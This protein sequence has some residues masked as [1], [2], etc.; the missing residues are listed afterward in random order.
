[1]IYVNG[2][3]DIKNPMNEK[4]EI[5]L[6]LNYKLNLKKNSFEYLTDKKPK[7]FEFKKKVT[8]SDNNFQ[9]VESYKYSSKTKMK[10]ENVVKI[11]RFSGKYWERKIILPNSDYKNYV[12][13][14]YGGKCNKTK[15][16]F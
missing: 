7:L 15:K 4:E 9:F 5:D 10:Y 12:V 11:N 14:I 6:I 16:K 13:I 1:M 8:I 2:I 3:P